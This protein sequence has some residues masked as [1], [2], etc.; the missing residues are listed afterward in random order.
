M[1]KFWYTDGERRATTKVVQD[2]SCD[3]YTT[4]KLTLASLCIAYHVSPPPRIPSCGVT[5]SNITLQ[6]ISDSKS[7]YNTTSQNDD[8]QQAVELNLLTTFSC[9]LVASRGHT[10]LVVLAAE[11]ILS[12]EEEVKVHRILLL[13]FCRVLPQNLPKGL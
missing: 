5:T 12:R 13:G 10:N 9:L 8:E 1:S 11:R 6:S 3:C 2:H 7:W 4:K